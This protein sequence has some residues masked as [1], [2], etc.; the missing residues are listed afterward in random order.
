M[1]VPNFN[2]NYLESGKMTPVESKI[3]E[4]LCQFI[5]KNTVLLHLDLSNM[6]IHSEMIKE[7]GP[8]LRKS[9]SILSLHLSGNPGVTKDVKK[10]LRQR[11]RC[12]P[13]VKVNHIDG[14][15]KNVTAALQ[16]TNSPLKHSLSKEGTFKAGQQLKMF[17]KD[18]HR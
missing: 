9:K 15:D 12:V 5:K 2:G 14:I 3:V 13:K 18:L 10:Y 11:V 8:A 4:N 1:R 17:T 6:G 16:N 7:F